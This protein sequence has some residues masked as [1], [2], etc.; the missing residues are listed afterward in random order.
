MS[1]IVK[2]LYRCSKNHRL[3]AQCA[4]CR[5]ASKILDKTSDR[6]FC[7]IRL[8]ALIEWRTPFDKKSL[9][10]TYKALEKFDKDGQG[11]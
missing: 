2:W 8:E 9:A 5:N 7:L 4:E 3:A 11:W 1:A 6:V 10:E